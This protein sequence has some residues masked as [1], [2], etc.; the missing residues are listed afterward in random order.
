[1]ILPIDSGFASIASPLIQRAK[2]NAKP[3]I[4]HF[5]AISETDFWAIGGMVTDFT[6][7][8]LVKELQQG[9]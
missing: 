1:M 3:T 2:H 9:L 8:C 5:P 4:G 6:S 7:A